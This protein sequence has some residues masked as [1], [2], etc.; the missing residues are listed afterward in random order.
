MS[1]TDALKIERNTASYL[2]PFIG[3][4]AEETLNNCERVISDLGYVV[5]VSEKSGL[6]MNWPDLFRVFETIV[7]AMRYESNA[8]KQKQGEVHV[9]S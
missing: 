1:R 6:Q 2:N 7:I 5:S 8:Q 3:I 9:Q 4:N